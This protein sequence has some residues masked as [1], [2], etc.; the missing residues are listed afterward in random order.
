M[1]D[2]VTLN[3]IN[4]TSNANKTL[5]LGIVIESL[6]SRHCYKSP[7]EILR[8]LDKKNLILNIVT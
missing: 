8:N 4:L 2:I 5:M 6:N 7:Y 3:E 1:L